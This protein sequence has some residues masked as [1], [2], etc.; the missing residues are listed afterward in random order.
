MEIIEITKANYK[1]YLPLN[2][3]AFSFA[4]PGAMGDSGAIVIVT[5]GG[6][7]YLANPFYGDISEDEVFQ[8]C[9]PLKDCQFG[10]FD[11]KI[12]KEWQYHYMG[13]GNHLVIRGDISAQFSAILEREEKQEKVFLIEK[14]LDIVF[15][16]IKIKL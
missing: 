11:G 7:V 13:C 5:T 8:V 1:E 15:E 10:I 12:P 2:I 4:S 16:I 14:W 9:P 6:V 3:V